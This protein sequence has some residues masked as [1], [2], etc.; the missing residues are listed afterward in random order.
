MTPDED[1][2]ARMRLIQRWTDKAIGCGKVPP[3]LELLTI[4][5]LVDDLATKSDL[6]HSRIGI[7]PG[8]RYLPD[9]EMLVDVA[10][11]PRFR[12]TVIDGGAS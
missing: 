10:S 11:K 8:P 5:D 3:A 4:R 12:F 2:W 1:F 7:Y 9:G 6:Y